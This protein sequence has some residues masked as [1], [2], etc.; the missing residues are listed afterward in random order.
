MRRP[1][2]LE[3]TGDQAQG[4]EDLGCQSC[5]PL[6]MNGVPFRQGTGAERVRGLVLAGA[7]PLP[8]LARFSLILGFNHAT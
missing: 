7:R 3:P 1:R 2:W 4:N 6:C 5:S 8:H